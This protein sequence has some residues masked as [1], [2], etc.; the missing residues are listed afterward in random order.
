[1]ETVLLPFLLIVDGIQ[2]TTSVFKRNQEK[3]TVA[4]FANVPIRSDLCL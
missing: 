4:V 2:A 1:M 3:L